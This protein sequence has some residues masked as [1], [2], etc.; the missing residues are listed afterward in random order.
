MLILLTDLCVLCMNA[1]IRV[2]GLLKFPS[3]H[4]KIVKK[5]IKPSP[6]FELRPKKLCHVFQFRFDCVCFR[7]WMRRVSLGENAEQIIMAK[8]HEVWPTDRR[9][10]VLPHKPFKLVKITTSSFFRKKLL[11][12]LNH[13]IKSIFKHTLVF[14]RKKN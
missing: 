13:Q 7:L 9:A 11:I 4:K 8:R 6:R 5:R 2:S 12:T 10:N 1:Y 14:T 3:V